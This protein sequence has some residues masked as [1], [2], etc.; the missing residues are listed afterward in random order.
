MEDASLKQQMAIEFC[1]SL[2]RNSSELWICVTRGNKEADKDRGT[3]RNSC[4]AEEQ[5]VNISQTLFWEAG[6]SEPDMGYF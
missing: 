6:I 1:M 5:M 4:I 2:T 3:E